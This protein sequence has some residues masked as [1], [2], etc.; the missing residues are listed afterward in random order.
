[1]THP[2]AMN[3]TQAFDCRGPT[4]EEQTVQ[5]QASSFFKAWYMTSSMPGCTGKDREVLDTQGF[6]KNCCEPISRRT[7]DDADPL[8]SS[9]APHFQRPFFG[10]PRMSASIPSEACC[11]S[12]DP[13]PQSR[14]SEVHCDTAVE[15]HQAGP[16]DFS[17][18]LTE[19]FPASVRS[20]LRRVGS[21]HRKHRGAPVG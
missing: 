6:A 7:V 3:S 14:D 16:A 2:P 5:R 11:D 21:C 8:S 17:E 15:K 19:L 13:L 4:P 10:A 1:M 18:L 20:R 12:R 9:E